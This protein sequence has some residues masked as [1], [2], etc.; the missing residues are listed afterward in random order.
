MSEQADLAAMLP[1]D[2]DPNHLEFMMLLIEGSVGGRPVLGYSGEYGWIMIASCECDSCK[3]FT[4]GYTA[5]P[6]PTVVGA[7]Y[8]YSLDRSKFL[9]EQGDSKGTLH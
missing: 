7:A 8:N 6:S 4:K 3:R 2:T 9:K 5:K 1:K